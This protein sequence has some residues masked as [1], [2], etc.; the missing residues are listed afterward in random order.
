MPEQPGG[1]AHVIRMVVSGN[2]PQQRAAG[3]SPGEVTFPQRARGIVPVAAI[4]GRPAFDAIDLVGQQPQIDVIECKRERHAQPQHAGC[5]LDHPARRG[6]D[7][8][9]K[10]Q[11]GRQMC[12]HEEGLRLQG[13]RT[14]ALCN[15][16]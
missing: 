7:R 11:G 13:R 2:D 5:D 16:A 14:V 10:K 15:A 4:D 3:E 1:V 9:R 12:G 8:V 6:Y